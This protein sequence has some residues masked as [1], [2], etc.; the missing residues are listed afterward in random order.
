MTKFQV[1]DKVKWND[2]IHHK[3]NKRIDV[4]TKVISD[5]WGDTRYMTEEVNNSK[6]QESKKG[7][8]YE[9]YLVKA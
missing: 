9:D 4:I 6:N 3:D 5:F 7:I 2:G 8:A 1:G